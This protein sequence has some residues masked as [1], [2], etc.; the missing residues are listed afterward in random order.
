MLDGLYGYSDV[1]LFFHNAA[2][3]EGRML[4]EFLTT[5]LRF[6]DGKIDKIDSYVSE[7]HM[8]NEFFV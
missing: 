2:S 8:L 6:Q 1:A 7:V 5:V 3:H 4:D